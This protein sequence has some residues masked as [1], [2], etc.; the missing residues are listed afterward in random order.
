MDTKRKNPDLLEIK[1]VL[2]PLKEG[3][4]NPCLNDE[5]CFLNY[6]GLGS[7]NKKELV[8]SLVR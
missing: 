6:R 1:V 3:T 2:F 7:G 8:R 4:Q 5:N